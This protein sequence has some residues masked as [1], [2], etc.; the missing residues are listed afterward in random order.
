MISP[1]SNNKEVI[2]KKIWYPMRN[3]VTT[4]SYQLYYTWQV[5]YIIYTSNYLWL[6][7]ITYYIRSAYPAT[8]SYQYL[9]SAKL[10]QVLIWPVNRGPSLNDIFPKL[11]NVKYLSLIHASSG[12]HNLK[13]DGWSSYLTTFVCQFGRYRYK[14][15]PFEAAPT[16]NIFQWKISKIFKNL[17]NVFIIAVTF[18]L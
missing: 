17:P 9:E 4:V 13:L 10:N 16:A 3:M 6:F 1:H 8:R 7:C 15:L 18:S 14:R 5:I 2:K 11:N 12:Y